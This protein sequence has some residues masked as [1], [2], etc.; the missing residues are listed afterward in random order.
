MV[1]GA[2]AYMYGIQTPGLTTLVTILPVYCHVI[3]KY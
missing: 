3:V 2:L 1:N